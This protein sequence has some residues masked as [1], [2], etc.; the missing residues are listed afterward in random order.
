MLQSETDIETPCPQRHILVMLLRLL[1]F[2]LILGYG[3]VL[4]LFSARRMGA[5]LEAKAR[6]LADP[7]LREALVPLAKAL[8]LPRIPVGI[9][10]DTAV[11]GLAA[12]DGKVYLTQGFV[13]KFRAG[14][15]TA[16]EIA[17]VVAHEL[18]HVALGHS[19]RRMIDYT[20]QNVLRLV[21]IGV[22]GRFLP[23]IG[24]WIANAIA[25]AFA[26]RL[27]RRDEFEAD[28][29]ASA[30][31]IKSGYS[32]APQKSLFAKLDALTGAE[33]TSIFGPS[34]ASQ[35]PAWLRTH[36]KTPQRIAAIEAN[37][38]RWGA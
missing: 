25:S 34:S 36:P 6:P 30:L 32:T 28:E 13:Q 3:L 4:W 17:S 33:T 10:P 7:A 14:E 27:S 23:F 21:L 31:M 35:I 16:P 26:A 20:G 5:Q 19:R 9:L 22:L 2:L 38:A 29:W 24:F 15:V 12:P 11:N 8:D 18:G 37:E 1:P